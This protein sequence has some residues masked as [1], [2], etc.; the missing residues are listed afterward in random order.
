MGHIGTA[1]MVL[2]GWCECF[3]CWL[4]SDAFYENGIA[5][6][7]T[8]SGVVFL[9]PDLGSPGH[10][11]QTLSRPRCWFYIWSLFQPS[12]ALCSCKHAILPNGLGSLGSTPYHL[13]TVSSQHYQDPKLPLRK[14]ISDHLLYYSWAQISA[15]ICYLQFCKAQELVMISSCRSICTI[16]AKY[17]KLVNLYRTKPLL[18]VW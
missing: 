12:T 10:H 16:I 3:I 6:D 13:P 2:Y 15:D 9:L 8:I 1:G 5:Q 14:G 11:C 17:F 18:I 7:N 4:V